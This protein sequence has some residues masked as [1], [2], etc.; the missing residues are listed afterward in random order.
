MSSRGQGTIPISTEFLLV[1][2]HGTA[3]KT[4]KEGVF[5]DSLGVPGDSFLFYYVP[6]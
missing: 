1:G 6:Y 4:L 3:I 2:G 5:S